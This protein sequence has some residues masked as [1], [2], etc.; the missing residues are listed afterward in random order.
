MEKQVQ[1]TKI[2]QKGAYQLFP[3]G[4]S[5]I[6]IK[7]GD[8]IRPEVYKKVQGAAALLASRRLPGVIELVPAYTTLTIYYNPWQVSIMGEFNPWLVMQKHVQEILQ[9]ADELPDMPQR[10]VEVPVCYAPA[11]GPD[12]DFVA[13][14]HQ[15]RIEEVVKIHTEAEYLVYMLGFVPGFP[16]MGGLDIKIA[17][18]RKGNPRPVI[19]AGSVGIAGEQTGIYPFSTPGGWQLIGQSPLCLFDPAREPP[20]FL[21]AGDQVKFVPISATEFG[22]IKRRQH[23]P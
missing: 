18:P 11:F 12:L 13:R 10:V 22:E 1:I 16:Y 21:R 20:T 2:K 4:D 5:A 15:L 8:Q 14:Y 6:V 19:P 9:Q 7:F 17:T 23:E 3:L